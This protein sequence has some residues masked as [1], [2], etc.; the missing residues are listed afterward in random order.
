MSTIAASSKSSNT[1][2]HTTQNDSATQGHQVLIPEVSIRGKPPTDKEYA[3]IVHLYSRPHEAVFDLSTGTI[4]DA[5]RWLG[6]EVELVRRLGHGLHEKQLSL[7][8]QLD[9]MHTELHSEVSSFQESTRNTN[10]TVSFALQN[11]STFEYAVVISFHRWV[12]LI[13]CFRPLQST[14]ESAS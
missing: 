14:D 11:V 1:S 2:K 9:E 4:E 7:E 6:H 5:L 8:K 10:Q 3:S 13:W 12:C